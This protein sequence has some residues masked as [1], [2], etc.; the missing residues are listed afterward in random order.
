MNLRRRSM[1][2]LKVHLRFHFKKHKKLQKKFKKKMHVTLQLMV[3]ST[4]QSRI[5]LWI[6]SRIFY[7]L[8]RAEQTELLTFSNEIQK[9]TFTGI[10]AVY[11]KSLFIS[12][13]LKLQTDSLKK[14]ST[15]DIF[16]WNCLL[17]Q[18]SF[19]RSAF[20]WWLLLLNT[21][22]FLCCVD[23]ISKMLRSTLAIFWLSLNIFKASTVSHLWAAVSG[24]PRQLVDFLLTK[25]AIRSKCS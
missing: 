17:F 15:R 14:D 3:H 25:Q 8:Y 2:H 5:H 19:L 7:M 10:I 12:F 16:W 4:M 18:N 24:N 11:R 13:L 1:S 22:H 6:S 23:L 20:G 21:I 9:Q